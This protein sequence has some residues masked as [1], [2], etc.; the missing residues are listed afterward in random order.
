ML[1]QVLEE[2]PSIV[3]LSA[4]PPFAVVHARRLYQ[5]LLAQS[6]D[7]KIVI[8]LWNS[9]GDPQQAATR[10]SG[11]ADGQVSRTLAH[12]MQQIRFL[13]GV[14]SQPVETLV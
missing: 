8:G 1:A 9:S 6:P 2:K 7:L 5:A 10:I 12:A 11:L 3:C 13:T 4:L 14:P